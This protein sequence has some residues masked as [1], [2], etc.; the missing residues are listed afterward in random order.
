VLFPNDN[1]STCGNEDDTEEI[2]QKWSPGNPRRPQSCRVT[3]KSKM[4]NP[5]R[6]ESQRKEIPPELQERIGLFTLFQRCGAGENPRA[7]AHGQRHKSA[8]PFIS[9]GGILSNPWKVQEHHKKKKHHSQHRCRR[10]RQHFCENTES[11]RNERHADKVR[12]EQPPR[13]KRRYQRCN[14]SA[15]NKML[16]PEND[17]G[18]SHKYAP[19]CFSL[20]GHREGSFRAPTLSAMLRNPQEL[21]RWMRPQ[22][23]LS[24][25]PA[26]VCGAD[27]SLP[28]FPSGV[29]G[30][31]RGASRFALDMCA[32]WNSSPLR[33]AIGQFAAVE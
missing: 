28:T 20:I 18:N 25:L 21:S 8:G 32:S 33:A 14:E 11:R 7:S 16:N 23:S 17:E 19:E 10:P 31:E 22:H 27:L 4:L 26:C 24:L 29:L 15:I 9:I 3:P 12:P 5:K 6:H 1:R 2:G 30:V 13:H